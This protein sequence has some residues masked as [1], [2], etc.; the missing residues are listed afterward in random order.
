MSGE[1]TPN[2]KTIS[3]SEL[4]IKL[5]Q[6]D[7]EEQL[8]VYAGSAKE[9]TSDHGWECTEDEGLDLQLFSNVGKI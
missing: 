8:A 1:Y 7:P 3:V 9:F 5:Q 2:F 6:L 4:I